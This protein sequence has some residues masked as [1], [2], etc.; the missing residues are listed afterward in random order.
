MGEN[1]NLIQAL[2]ITISS[3][4]MVFIILLVI[5]GVLSLFKYIFKKENDVKASNVKDISKGT[6]N[7]IK[8]DSVQENINIDEDEKIVVALAASIMAGDGIPNP[9]LHIK[10]ITRIS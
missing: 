4:A 1:L 8:N 7:N 5:S 2:Y 6:V 10:R 9:N 3:M